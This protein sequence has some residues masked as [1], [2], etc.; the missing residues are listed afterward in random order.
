MDKRAIILS[1][2]GVV[3]LA[4]F[5]W[6]A[7]TARAERAVTPNT[8]TSITAPREQTYL[9]L[10]I[11]MKNYVP[12]KPLWRFG[13]AQIRRPFTDYDHN[14]IV[15]MRFGWYR[16]FVATPNAPQPY[17]IEYSPTIR[18]KQ[19]KLKDANTWTQCC[20]GCP[21][22]E[23]YTYTVSLSASQIQA[24]ATSRPG[25][26]WAIGNEIER[27]DWSI[28]GYC[29]RQDEML[30][31]VYARVYRDLYYTIKNA[32]PTAQVAIG[33]MVGFTD[34]RRR[35]LDRVWAEYRRLYGTTMPVD[36]WNVHLYVLQEKSCSAFPNDCW[37]AGI[38]AGFTENTGALYT[39]L[40]NKDFT[41]AWQFVV[42]LRSW[43]SQNGQRHKPL[44]TS[45]YGVNMPVWMG[46]PNYP[47]TT[48]CPFTPEQV[49]DSFLYPSFNTF[50]NATDVNIGYPA[51][52]NRLIQ[53]W[54]WWSLDYDDGQCVDGIFEEYFNG[55]LFYS[56]LGP[57]G[58]KTCTYPSQGISNLGRYWKQY[59]QNLPSGSNKPYASDSVLDVSS[60]KTVTMALPT[61]QPATVDCPTERRVR[62]EFYAPSQAGLS[63]EGLQGRPTRR[64]PLV[65]PKTYD[66]TICLP[67][68]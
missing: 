14:D 61:Y 5:V 40:D 16:N 65:P 38:P 64:Q 2:I 7:Q 30:P 59:V 23:P 28:D 10:P 48:G 6:V 43:M 12:P 33:G 36:V 22:V 8:N 58:A 51:D 60:R 63:I 35:Y 62:L 3:G 17:E 27:I 1:V 15:A 49:R 68:Q 18:V 29:A 67:A 25:M 13:I 9:Y 32:D 53:R 56:G 50:L 42:A 24:M 45:E 47:N 57:S 34:L 4:L 41:K 19:W 44:I 55:A 54:N 46:C 66:M 11:V 39:P 52:G 20:V 21:Y 26:T 31:E 37:G